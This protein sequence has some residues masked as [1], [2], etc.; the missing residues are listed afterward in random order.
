MPGAKKL[1]NAQTVKRNTKL[2]IRIKK[3]LFSP[4]GSSFACA[5]TEGLIIYS[6]RPENSLFNPFDIDEHVTLEGIIQSIKDEQHL[7]ALL[8]RK[9]M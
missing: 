5:T 3:V 2:A 9:D 1:N 4:D 6:L 7:S 8:V